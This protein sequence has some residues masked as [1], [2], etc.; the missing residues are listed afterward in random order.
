MS[1][2]KDAAALAANRRDL[3]VNVDVGD[4]VLAPA[5]T[6]TRIFCRSPVVNYN[7]VRHHGD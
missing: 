3:E 6:V 2:K 7:E 5:A 1:L 4:P